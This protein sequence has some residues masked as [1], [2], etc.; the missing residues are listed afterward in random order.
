MADCS[1]KTK[2]C[3]ICKNRVEKK[4]SCD[5]CIYSEHPNVTI[6][7]NTEN[8]RYSQ[9]NKAMNFDYTEPTYKFTLTNNFVIMSINDLLEFIDK[10]KIE[11]Y[12]KGDS[13][14]GNWGK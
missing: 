6:K 1:N 8:I 14:H 7:V 2:I 13:D 10:M 5:S 11:N 12:H 9:I 3:D 4:T